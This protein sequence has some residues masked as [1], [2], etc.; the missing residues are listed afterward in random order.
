MG[1]A[2]IQLG[3]RDRAPGV[4]RC[5][6]RGNVRAATPRCPSDGRSRARDGWSRDTRDPLSPTCQRWPSSRAMP[7]RRAMRSGMGG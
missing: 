4:L 5:T 6:G 2:A 7:S 1:R 3:R